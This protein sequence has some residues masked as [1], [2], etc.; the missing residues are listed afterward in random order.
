MGYYRRFIPNFSKVAKP[1]NILLQNLEG[2]SNQ[3]KK[4]KIQWGSEQQ[5]A[6]EMLQR[7]CTEAQYW[8]MQISKLNLS[9]TLMPVVMDTGKCYTK[10]K[11]V[12]GGL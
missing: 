7:L 3:K 8:H 2:T 9:F 10:T 5:E 12:K 1:L 4:F 6:F 11:M